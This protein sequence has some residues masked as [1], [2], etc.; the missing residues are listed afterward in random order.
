VSDTPN[1]IASDAQSP[2]TN[3]TPDQATTP[4]QAPGEAPV[5]RQDPAIYASKQNAIR[6]YPDLG[7][8]GSDFNVRFLALHKKYMTE[9][10][11]YF[12]DPEWPLTLAREVAEGGH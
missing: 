4:S 7:V 9:R 2:R 6:L 12:R 1:Q 5:S 11:D 10:P 3:D 8:A